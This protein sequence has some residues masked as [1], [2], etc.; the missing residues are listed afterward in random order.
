MNEEGSELEAKLRYLYD[1]EKLED[2]PLAWWY[3]PVDWFYR[4]GAWLRRR[5]RQ[6]DA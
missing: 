3:Y 4:A 6:L 1:D 2:E 5:L